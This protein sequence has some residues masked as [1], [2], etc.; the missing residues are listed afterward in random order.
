MSDTSPLQKKQKME[1]QKII[2]THNGTFHCDEALAVFLLRQTKSFTGADLKRSRDPALLDGCDIVVDVGAIYDAAAQRFDHHQRGF[3]EVF[4]HGFTTKLSSAGLIYK[5]FG[6]EIIAARTQLPVDDPKVHTLWLKMYQEF[7]EAID[8]ND[9][10]IS[11][12]PTEIKPLYKSSTD[13]PSRVS[14]LNPAWNQ[15]CDAQTLDT[16]FAKASA[17]TGGEF[18]AKLDFYANAWLPA[19]DL[20]IDALQKSKENVD[21]TGKLILL[22]QFLPWKGHLFDLERE[23]LVEPTSTYVVYSDD[24]G[25]WRVQAVPVSEDS[26]ESRKPLPEAWRGVRDDALSKISGVEGCVFVHASGFIGG[27]KTKEG[28][29]QLARLALEM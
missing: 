25:N 13:L 15:P 1:H 8:A 20:L 10:G 29:L 16:Q 4:G 3:E 5:H 26:F 12:Y 27:T 23:S 9:N 28:A 18:L 6:K 7:I 11:R 22:E 2:G 19:R 24:G 14:S 17:L 21:A